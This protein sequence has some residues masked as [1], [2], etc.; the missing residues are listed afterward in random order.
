M[1]DKPNKKKNTLSWIIIVILFVITA[2][3]SRGQIWDYERGTVND[4]WMTSFMYTVAPNSTDKVFRSEVAKHAAKNKWTWYYLKIE[5][6]NVTIFIL[7]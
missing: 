3:F 7:Y 1:S 4:N 2:I 6:G 5:N